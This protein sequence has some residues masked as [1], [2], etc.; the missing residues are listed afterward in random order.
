MPI[1]Q[2]EMYVLAESADRT[3]DVEHISQSASHRV[4][5][6]RDQIGQSAVLWVKVPETQAR[7]AACE[8]GGRLSDA[9]VA[10]IKAA[11]DSFSVLETLRY[12]D[13]PARLQADGVFE[14]DDGTVRPLAKARIELPHRGKQLVRLH[15]HL[16]FVMD[17]QAGNAAREAVGEF[18]NHGT[19]PRVQHIDATV[20][21]DHRQEPMMRH[22]LQNVLKFVR[23]VG[24]HLGAQTHLGEAEPS[25][26]E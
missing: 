15:R 8:S 22:E 11:T 16:R 23:R 3:G 18:P 21:V 4:L 6:V 26:L 2:V 13:V 9:D 12:L 24:I 1:V 19:A 10:D 7:M 20:Q 5:D 25:K 14:K 17:D